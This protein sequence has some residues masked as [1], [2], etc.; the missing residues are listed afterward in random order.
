MV[1]YFSK[2]VLFTAIELTLLIY[3]LIFQMLSRI[4][5][6]YCFFFENLTEIKYI[7]RILPRIFGGTKNRCNVPTCRDVQEDLVKGLIL[8]LIISGYQETNFIEL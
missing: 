2:S 1:K 5:L 7:N 4:H 6:S 3:F 8:Y